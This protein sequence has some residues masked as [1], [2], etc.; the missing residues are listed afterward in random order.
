MAH[1][2][3]VYFTKSL[4]CYRQTLLKRPHS[5]EHRLSVVSWEVLKLKK[6]RLY[7][8]KLIK[9]K[10]GQDEKKNVILK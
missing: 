3:K 10:D 5:N 7:H 6:T 2:K 8:K 4:S 1:L 9:I